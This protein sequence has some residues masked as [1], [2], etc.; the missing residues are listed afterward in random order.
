MG[1]MGGTRIMNMILIKTDLHPPWSPFERG[2]LF[3]Q[4]REGVLGFEGFEHVWGNVDSDSARDGIDGDLEEVTVHFI[5]TTDQAGQGSFDDFYLHALAVLGKGQDL[6]VVVLQLQDIGDL[7]L[8]DGNRALAVAQDLNDTDAFQ[9]LY[10]PLSVQ[11]SPD[12]HVPRE[13]KLGQHLCPVLA[14]AFFLV[15]QVQG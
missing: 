14:P 5:D 4:V 3:D 12:E 8:T 15:G 1:V 13:K 6:S 11:R 9:D 10:M 7:G 2:S